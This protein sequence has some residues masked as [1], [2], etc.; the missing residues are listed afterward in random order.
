MLFP[1]AVLASLFPKHDLGFILQSLEHILGQQPNTWCICINFS[2]L[3][4]ELSS[5]LDFP[6]MLASRRTSYA[7]P[8]A[9]ATAVLKNLLHILQPVVLL[10]FYY[11]I[12]LHKRTYY[13]LRLLLLLHMYYKYS[14]VQDK[15]PLINTNADGPAGLYTHTLS[16]SHLLDCSV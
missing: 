10:L 14:F 2:L 6:Y 13:T 12:L 4:K 15:C 3:E 16:C 11:I 8:D 7:A 1:V 5:I 9:L